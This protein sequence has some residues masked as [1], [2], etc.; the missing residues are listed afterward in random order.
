MEINIPGH[1]SKINDFLE[2]C[3]VLK[4][5]ETKI[6]PSKDL[7][8]YFFILMNLFNTLDKKNLENWRNMH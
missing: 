4:Y 6:D 8:F 5:V 2:F 7:N 1:H 3:L